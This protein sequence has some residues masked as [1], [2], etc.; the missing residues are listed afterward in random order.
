MGRILILSLFKIVRSRWLLAEIKQRRFFFILASSTP[1]RRTVQI[2]LPSGE[3]LET[4]VL[5][6]DE[7]GEPKDKGCLA[8]TYEECRDNILEKARSD[9][10]EL[11]YLI[12]KL[13]DISLENKGKSS[14]N[15]THN[16]IIKIFS[17]KSK[18]S[19]C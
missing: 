3:L 9:P 18:L 8:H 7:T 6:V 11:D 16:R 1:G 19:N 12:H 10:Y 2:R 4:E 14:G 5:Y 13:L 17:V 15:A